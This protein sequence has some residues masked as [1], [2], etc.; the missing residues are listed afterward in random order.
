MRVCIY[1]WQGWIPDDPTLNAGQRYPT[2]AGAS[3][4]YCSRPGVMALTFDDGPHIFTPRLLDYLRAQNIKAT[5][6]ING[7]NKNCIYNATFA[8]IVRRA[9]R[10]GHQIAS[11]SWSHPSVRGIYDQYGA[12]AVRVELDRVEAAI[13]KII[14]YRPRYFRPP[15]GE[16]GHDRVLAPIFRERGYVVSMW[17]FATIDANIDDGLA[18]PASRFPDN[19]INAATRRAFW[20][21]YYGSTNYR[22]GVTSHSVLMHDPLQRT[23]RDLAPWVVAQG[24]RL[25]YRFVTFGECQGDT[26]WRRWYKPRRTGVN[27]T[28]LMTPDASWVCPE[29]G[30]A[31][32][33]LPWQPRCSARPNATAIPRPWR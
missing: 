13:E 25:G 11:H 8:N 26:D 3:Y 6:F 20:V 30:P 31:P 32:R 17:T 28:R 33:C 5:F 2:V 12:A 23:V 27:Y 21:G 10:E 16:G 19:V 1:G 24:R 9:F 7:W 14:G 4:Q 22:P 29:D 15:Y 18:A